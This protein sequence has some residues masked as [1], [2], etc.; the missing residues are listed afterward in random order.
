MT[1]SIVLRK[2][3]KLFDVNLVIDFAM[4]KS[5][6]DIHMFKFPVVDGGK[7][8]KMALYDIGLTTNAKVSL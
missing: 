6:F 3:S 7:W 2:T 1:Y 5:C 8:K 4:E